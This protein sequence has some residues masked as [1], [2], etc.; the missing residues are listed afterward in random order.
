MFV[1][2]KA[3]KL[4]IRQAMEQI[5]EGD[6]TIRDPETPI[7]THIFTAVDYQPG[8]RD[9]RWNVVSIAGRQPGE[10]EKSSGMNSNRRNASVEA[11]PTDAA[12]A[13][14]AL[15]RV[16]IPQETAQRISELVLPGSSLIVSDE[17][18]HKETNKATDFIVLI[19]GEPQGGIILRP[20][21]PSRILRRLLRWRLWLG[22]RQPG[23]RRLRQSPP[24]ARRRSLW[25]VRRALQVVVRPSDLR[26]A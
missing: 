15:D 1:S 19:S 9:M 5:Y 7:G 8:G 10:P 2:L 21:A 22:L 25:P 14:A 20:E 11:I 4:Y 6:V 3:K 12:A 18:A 13:K 23:L 26:A 17:A 24:P 16:D